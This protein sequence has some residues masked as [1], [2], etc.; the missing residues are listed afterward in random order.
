MI[1]YTENSK[2]ATEK[3]LESI[4]KLSMVAGYKIEIEKSVAFLYTEKAQV[5]NE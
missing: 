2:K 4:N 3:L 5:E 1:L